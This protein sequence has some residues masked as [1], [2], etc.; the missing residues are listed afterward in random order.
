MICTTLLSKT[1]ETDNVKKNTVNVCL[2]YSLHVRVLGGNLPPPKK[3][4]NNV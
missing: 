1:T 2:H 3:Q 4:K